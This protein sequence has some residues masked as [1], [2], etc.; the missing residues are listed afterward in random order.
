MI[1]AQFIVFLFKL[2]DSGFEINVSTTGQ[3]APD[4]HL[5]KK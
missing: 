2:K 4:G 3:A 1:Y 5:L